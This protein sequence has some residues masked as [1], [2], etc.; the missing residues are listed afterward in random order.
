ME[1]LKQ[2]TFAEACYNQ[3]SINEL[4]IALSEE[5]D[6]TDMR[7]WNITPIEWYEQIMLALA[8]RRED[9]GKA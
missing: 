7:T 8:A 5:P 6:E 3:N 1:S 2:N 4:K 9:I